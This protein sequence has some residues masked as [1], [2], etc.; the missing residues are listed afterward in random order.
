MEIVMAESHVMAALRQ[1]R[2]S[3]AG[4]IVAVERR[5]G[6]LRAALVHLDGSMRL[7]AGE[8]FNPEAIVPKLPRPLHA[9][10]AVIPRGDLMRSVLDALRTAEAGLTLPGI[11]IRVAPAIGVELQD[12]RE[13][14]LL[15]ERIRNALYRIR[16]KGAAENYRD[17][18]II[19][20]RLIE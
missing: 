7:F 9:L 19:Y 1:K 3:V 10:P 20:W 6:E 17:G 12:N 16:D 18:A 2:A 5:I 8:D 11:A 15:N 14:Q 4:E 13:R